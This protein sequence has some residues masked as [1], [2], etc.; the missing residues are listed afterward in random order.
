MGDGGARRPGWNPAQCLPSTP[1]ARCAASLAEACSYKNGG[2]NKGIVPPY[3]CRSP[4]LLGDGGAQPPGVESGT[5]PAI[6]PGGAVRRI[7][8]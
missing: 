7:A 8:G 3:L 2:H 4:I 1:A 6:H 5:V